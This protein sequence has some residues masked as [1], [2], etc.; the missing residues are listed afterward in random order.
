MLEQI[1]SHL[2]NYFPL[3]I[4]RGIFVIEDGALTLPG[5]PSGGYFRIVGSRLNDGVYRYP[6]EGLNDEI[7]CGQVWEL[8]IPKALLT[9]ASEIAAW[10][11]RYGAA[12]DSPYQSE[13][14]IGVYAYAKPGGAPCGWQRAF[15][16]RLDEWRRLA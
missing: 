13:N 3:A 5:F 9:L 4:R 7:F 11:G 12:A 6:A 2:H 15:A 1:L 14:V 8:R 10:Q 16:A